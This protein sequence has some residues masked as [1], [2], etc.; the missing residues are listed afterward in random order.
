MCKFKFNKILSLLDSTQM[1]RWVKAGQKH[2]TAS[3]I[4]LYLRRRYICF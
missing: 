3:H 1:T 4:K 2:L